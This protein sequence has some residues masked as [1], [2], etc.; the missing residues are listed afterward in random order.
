M[1]ETNPY[2][3]QAFVRMTLPTQFALCGPGSLIADKRDCTGR[4]GS[5]ER[6]RPRALNVPPHRGRAN[7][8]RSR[9]RQAGVTPGM[10]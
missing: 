2:N 6:Y 5:R 8:G 1:A 9:W 10:G 4:P 3:S 7:L